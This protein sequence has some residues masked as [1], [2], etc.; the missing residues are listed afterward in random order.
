MVSKDHIGSFKHCGG[1][2]EL[3][4]LNDLRGTIEIENLELVKD[5]ISETKA[6][7]LKEKQ[8]LNILSLRW[9]SRLDDVINVGDDENL[10]DGLQPPQNLKY[11][12]VKW[13][14]GVRFSIWLSS[15]TNLI[16]LD[17]T[18]ARIANICHHSINCHLFKKLLQ[19]LPTLYQL[20][21]LQ[22]ISL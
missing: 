16:A 7:N 4:K 14:G 10:L 20:P 22:R 11:F 6:A 5:A 3:N 9:N 17:K 15:L 13:Y 2:A 18:F 12:S 1:L 8:H 21:S 19:E